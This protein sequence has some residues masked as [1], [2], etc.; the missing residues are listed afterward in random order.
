[1]LGGEALQD[2]QLVGYLLPYFDAGTTLQ[3][4]AEIVVN[5]GLMTHL[6]GGADNK[7]YVDLIYKN[8]MGHAPDAA[9]EASLKALL[10]SH[11]YSKAEFLAAI[12]ASSF[13]QANV[14]LV[15]L[16]SAGL[17]YV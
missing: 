1:V 11:Q 7:S 3:Q 17:E 5:N 2:R 6:A 8:V 10:D 16:A 14:D 13:N 9:F 12:A 4:A 15:G